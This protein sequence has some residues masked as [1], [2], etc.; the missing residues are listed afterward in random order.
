MAANEKSLAGLHHVTAITADAQKNID[1][2]CGVLG[3]RLVKLTVNFDDPGSYHLYY[4]D[5]LGRPGTIMTFFAW[6]GAHRGRIGPPQ[7]SA[8]AFAV[9]LGAIDYWAKRLKEHS[10]E[11]QPGEDRFGE[12]ILGFADPDGMRLEL[13]GMADPKGQPWTAGPIPVD[14]AIR[15]FH[16][17]TI[18]EEGHEDTAKLLTDVMKFKSVGT[19]K[20]RFRYQAGVGDGFASMVDLLCV[21]D[22]R[23]GDLGAGIVHHVAFRTADDSQQK[24]WLKEIGSLGFNISPVMDRTYFHSIYYREP[25]GVLF[26]IATENPGFTAHEPAAKFGTRLMLPPWLERNREEIERIVTPVRLPALKK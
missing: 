15:G 19:E 11:S 16:G 4:G 6:A 25:G 5:E 23:R 1:F 21:P 7:V 18:S 9:P 17:I 8:T 3:L 14:H 12:R 24:A 13:V 20:N 22:A 26:E 2:Y 10:T